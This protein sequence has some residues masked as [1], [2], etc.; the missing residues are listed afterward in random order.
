M[1]TTGLWRGRY[2]P[3]YADCC[4]N[5]NTT[6]HSIYHVPC[7]YAVSQ[8]CLFNTGCRSQ[9][10]LVWIAGKLFW[11]R[12][13]HTIFLKSNILNKNNGHLPVLRRIWSSTTNTIS[14]FNV[15]YEINDRKCSRTNSSVVLELK[16][17]FRRLDADLRIVDFHLIQ[18]R[19]I[20]SRS[21]I[22]LIFKRLFPFP[23]PSWNVNVGTTSTLFKTGNRIVRNVTELGIPDSGYVN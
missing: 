18:R 10:A 2:I 21:I 7:S 17:E 11:Q 13:E 20:P 9:M 5:K 14:H 15:S 3:T 16:I 23:K 1:Y 12:F 19:L 4:G 6:A 22:N 8:L